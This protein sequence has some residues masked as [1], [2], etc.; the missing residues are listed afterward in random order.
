M[1]FILFCKFYIFVS[2]IYC[3]PPGI[4]KNGELLNITSRYFLGVASYKCKPGHQLVGNNTTTC[5]DH[6]WSHLPVCEG[7]CFFAFILRGGPFS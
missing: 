4:L 2:D 5:T 3:G 1:A 7:M 6:G